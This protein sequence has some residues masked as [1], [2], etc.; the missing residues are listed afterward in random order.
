MIHDLRKRLTKTEEAANMVSQIESVI[1][2]AINK[3]AYWLRMNTK[4]DVRAERVKLFLERLEKTNN[5]SA[6]GYAGRRESRAENRAM[7]EDIAAYVAER[8]AVNQEKMA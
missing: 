3:Y 4:P 6:M 2:D 7:L 8:L 5:D 1:I